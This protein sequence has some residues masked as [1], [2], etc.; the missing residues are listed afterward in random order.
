M[1]A[2]L[3]LIIAGIVGLVLLL[4]ALATCQVCRDWAFIDQN[5]GAQKGYR[6]WFFGLRTGSWYRE[7][8]LETFMRAKHPGE[9]RQGWISYA[10]TGRNALGN[11]ILRGHGR[12]G[13]I[14]QLR[15]E[16]IDDY[17]GQAT[18]SETKQLYDLFASGERDKVQKAVDAVI[19]KVID[20][21]IR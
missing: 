14:F 6:E 5:T 7:T 2:R 12:P 20:E 16:M 21:K 19:E 1:K 8:R 3:I 13:P 9:F 15:P 11:A 10:G 4:L 17:C 18:E